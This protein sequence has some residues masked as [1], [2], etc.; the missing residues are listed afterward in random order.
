MKLFVEL[1]IN[2]EKLRDLA[3]FLLIFIVLILFRNWYNRYK[4]R[5]YKKLNIGLIDKLDKSQKENTDYKEQLKKVRIIEDKLVR[6]QN[7]IIE[8]KGD[9]DEHNQKFKITLSKKEAEIAAQIEKIDHLEKAYK[10]YVSFKN[11]EANNT[12]LGAHFIKNVI[13]QIYED[14]EDL[15]SG[16]KTFFGIHFKI[17]KTKQKILPIKA[18]KNIFKLLD[19]NVSALNKDNISLEE[20]LDHIYLF[21]ELIQYLKPSAKITLNNSLSKSQKHTLRIKPTL[22]FPFIENALKHGSL[23]EENSFITIE[24][25]EN[26]EKQLSYCLVNSTEQTLTRQDKDLGVTNFGLK[27]L[28]ELLNAYYPKSTLEHKILPNNQYLSELTLSLN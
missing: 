25:K 17:R 15:Q 10:R 1:F 5:S 23:N 19:Y 16:Y 11:V 9:I 13:S 28:Q 2:S 14:L 21:L 18:L 6:K 26:S 27:S 24:L 4:K 20:E 7:E 12:R 8:L 22:F 3:P